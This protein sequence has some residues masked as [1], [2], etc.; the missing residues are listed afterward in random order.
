MTQHILLTGKPRTGKTTLLKRIIKGLKFSCGGFYTEEIVK[1]N[2]RVG[3]KIK[4]LDGEEGI[5]AEKH[6]KSRFR[7]GK[8]GINLEDLEGIGVKAI[9]EALKTKQIVVIDEIGKM[10]LF[11]RR[12][13][14]AVLKT[15]DSGKRL[16][17]VIHLADDDF[18]NAI[19]ARKDVVIFEVNLSNHEEVLKK[20]SSIL[21]LNI[22]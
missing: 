9:E 20:I 3:F 5:L 18:L 10:E 1:D 6:R 19:R 16:I 12:F 15:L 11:S 21:L 7:L 17:G 4:T 14:N 22:I 2:Q 8:Y 13:K